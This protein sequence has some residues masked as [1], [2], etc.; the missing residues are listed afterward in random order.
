MIGGLAY[1]WAAG[2]ALG[3]R[4]GASARMDSIVILALRTLVDR[5]GIVRRRCVR[6][7]RTNLGR[8]SCGSASAAVRDLLCKPLRSLLNT[9]LRDHHTRQPPHGHD[10]C[11]PTR[12][13]K[14][15]T[16]PI[17]QKRA[18]CRTQVV[19]KRPVFAATAHLA[20][21]TGA[22]LQAPPWRWRARSTCHHEFARIRRAN[23]HS[24][25]EFDRTLGEL[26]PLSPFALN[27]PTG[28]RPAHCSHHT[29]N[30][31]PRPPQGW[32]RR[33]LRR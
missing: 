12:Y 1:A 29:H 4:P 26:P 5:C 2:A 9:K 7:S 32:H 31:S 21:G 10:A 11:Q 6:E 23:S 15:A 33:L 8:D 28:R 3:D 24:A 14:Y 25:A 19:S 30:A 17:S 27:S 18:A 13:S 16:R 20:S 22:W